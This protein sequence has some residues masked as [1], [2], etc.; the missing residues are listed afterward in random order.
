VSEPVSSHVIMVKSFDDLDSVIEQLSVS[1]CVVLESLE[2]KD[3]PEQGGNTVR[4]V[5][6]G[7]SSVT[8]TA[9]AACRFGTEISKSLKIESDTSAT[10]VAPPGKP[11]TVAV[12][13]S[14]DG[15]D[16]TTSALAYSY[17][18]ARTIR[19]S[20]FGMPAASSCFLLFASLTEISF[21]SPHTQDAIRA[22]AEPRKSHVNT[23]C[24]PLTWLRQARRPTR[25]ISSMGRIQV[26]RT[27][28]TCSQSGVVSHVW[29]TWCDIVL[30]STLEP[31]T[32]TL[33]SSVVRARTSPPGRSCSMDKWRVGGNF[34]STHTT[35]MNMH[36]FA[37]VSSFRAPD[38]VML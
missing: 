33:R 18:A 37:F 15:K 4:I 12:D 38:P 34:R 1:L 30:L 35:G 23:S 6:S 22:I 11:G 7:L 26:Q 2:P 31:S 21:A 9:D 13:I 25:F 32:A 20:P 28:G 5:G 10:C 27:L 17:R 29:L 3:G 19:V 8:P 36:R 14:F 24:T 16:Y